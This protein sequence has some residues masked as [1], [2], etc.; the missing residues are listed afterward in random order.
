MV[1]GLD[2]AI[3][4]PSFGEGFLDIAGQCH[5]WK[6]FGNLMGARGWYSAS[7]FLLI[8]SHSFDFTIIYILIHLFSIQ[9]VC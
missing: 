6:L 2:S 4:V 3:K 9:G 5:L 1:P 8:F 7:T